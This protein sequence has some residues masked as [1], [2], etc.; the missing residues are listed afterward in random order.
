M[1]RKS[2]AKAICEAVDDVERDDEKKRDELDMAGPSD[3]DKVVTDE[4]EEDPEFAPDANM[5]IKDQEGDVPLEPGVAVDVEGDPRVETLADAAHTAWSGWMEYLFGKAVENEDGSL[6]IPADQAQR[7]KR[8][9]ATSY[10]ELSDE[11]K[12][13]DREEARKYIAVLDGSDEEP[14]ATEPEGVPP[15]VG[16]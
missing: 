2:V 14:P 7:W 11:E 6:T 10:A 8:Q 4:P 1:N 13:S 3:I 16:S 12:E 5:T 15:A 9:A